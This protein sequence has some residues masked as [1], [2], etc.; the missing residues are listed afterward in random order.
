MLYIMCFYVCN[1]HYVYMIRHIYMTLV[2]LGK[3]VMELASP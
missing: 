1:I 2:K 3:K